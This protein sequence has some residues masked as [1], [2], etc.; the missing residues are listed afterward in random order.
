ML[1]SPTPPKEEM[2][3]CTSLESTLP[4]RSFEFC[5][6]IDCS[7]P[8]TSAA[9]SLSNCARETLAPS[10]SSRTCELTSQWQRTIFFATAM[11]AQFAGRS[12]SSASIARI[13]A[14]ISATESARFPVVSQDSKRARV[15]MPPGCTALRTA[16]WFSGDRS[17]RACDLTI[18]DSRTPSPT[19]LS[20]KA[21]TSRWGGAVVSMTGWGGRHATSTNE[22]S[23][24]ACPPL[25]S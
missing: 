9:A 3:P 13:P 11:T 20:N 16:W 21:S 10:G 24:S 18:R 22:H 6:T 15:S 25:E 5:R 2:R 8:A 17:Q 1:P 19:R 12:T 4:S 14:S 7:M 23:A